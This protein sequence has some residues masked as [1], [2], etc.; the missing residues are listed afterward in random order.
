MNVHCHVFGID[1]DASAGAT[2]PVTLFLNINNSQLADRVDLS[3]KR[4]LNLA[5]V[6]ILVGGNRQNGDA[7]PSIAAGIAG[8][9]TFDLGNNLSLKPS[10]V[11]S[12][13]HIDGADLLS[14]G[15]IGGNVALQYQA[16]RGGL[17]LRPVLYAT[18]Q[19]DILERMDY[20]LDGEVWQA[21]GWGMDLT[22]ALGYS[23][24]ESELLS[25]DDREGSYGRLGLKI[26]LLDSSNLEL[27]YGFNTTKGTLASQFR[28]NQGPS[29]STHL[30]LAPGWQIDGGYSL[31][32]VERGYDNR[33][34]D[35]RR[36]DMRH[37]LHLASD[38]AITSTTGAEWHISAGYDYEQ[39]FTDGPM[40]PPPTHRALVNFALNF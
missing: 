15:G 5:G 26:G 16:S 31:L 24:R 7:A 22:A 39:T 13:T 19:R 38:W 32:A 1:H 23:R 6:P 9:Y 30:A 40:P 17:L 10:G 27:A 34:T 28:F 25:T 14:G 4:R 37:R 3:Q 12:R 18:M 33:D 11:L 29:M 35:A 36:H 21:I 8:G 2:Q 20:A